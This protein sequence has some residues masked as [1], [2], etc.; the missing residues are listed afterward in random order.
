M[1]K[2]EE[3]SVALT[4]DYQAYARYWQPDTLRG[5]VLYHHGIQSHCGWYESSPARLCD[6]G[7]AVLQIDRRGSGH[8]EADRGHAESA[9]Q[10][11]ADSHAARRELTRRS[12][13]GRHHLVGVSWG[14]KLVAADYV[15]DPS[16]VASLSLVT[17][18]LFPLVG[19]SKETM[20]KI[21]F[22]MIYEQS[23]LFDI[24]LNDPK[25]FTSSADWQAFHGRDAL[26]LTQCTAGFYLAS[27]RMDRMIAK[28]PQATPTPIHFLLAG[29]ELIIDNPKTEAYIESFD[30]PNVTTTR[31]PA[32]KHS[33]EF[34]PDAEQYM[35]DLTAF[36]CEAADRA[37]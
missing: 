34:E 26:T 14:G 5:A 4:N 33:I 37:S 30:W 23:R 11:V 7:F 18:G 27:R 35:T 9:D 21:G 15:I 29:E 6:A 22:A 31:Y 17:P 8:N 12:G 25:L 20:S 1:A 13:V 24:P 10:L 28:L 32:S 36:I 3:I 2:F 19:V 16:N